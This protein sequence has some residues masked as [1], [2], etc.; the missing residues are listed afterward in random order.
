MYLQGGEEA[1]HL[2]D[3]EICPIKINKQYKISTHSNEDLLRAHP[4]LNYIS[5]ICLPENSL[6]CSYLRK[7]GR[8]K[9]LLESAVAVQQQHALFQLI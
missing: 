3:L 6:S 4:A 7:R 5:Q 2:A 9:A 1:P 8:R